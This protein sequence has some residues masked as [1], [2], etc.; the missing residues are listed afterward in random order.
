MSFW[1]KKTDCGQFLVEKC[2]PLCLHTQSRQKRI[3][4]ANHTPKPNTNDVCFWTMTIYTQYLNHSVRGKCLYTTIL[5]Q[6]VKIVSR[7]SFEK[8]YQN[9]NF[10][11][12]Y[13]VRG[14][15]K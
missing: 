6:N 14:Q 13:I 1:G 8:K 7:L 15:N 11:N 9:L 10:D 12:H 4:F 5:W 3:L 2:L